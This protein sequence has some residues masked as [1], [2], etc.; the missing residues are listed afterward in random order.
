MNSRDRV[1]SR[2][3][4]IIVLAL[5]TC[6][7]MVLPVLA[8][9]TGD[10]SGGGKN[11]PL[12][13]VASSPADGQKD[14]PLT[15]TIKLSFNKNVI[16]LLIRDANKSCISLIA[17]DG[18]KVP[19][20]VIMADDQTPEGFEQRR[21]IS[22]RP[23]QGLQPGTAYAV[24]ISPQLQAKNGTSLGHE[25]TVRF[26]TA[27]VASKPVANMPASNTEK[28]PTTTSP[29]AST[30]IEKNAAVSSET[31]SP[32]A[33]KAQ[34]LEEAQ[35]AEDK[36]QPVEEKTPES[37]PV[38]NKITYAIVAGLILLAALGYVYFRKRNKK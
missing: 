17:P 34:T 18:S 8:E 1:K 16:Y 11:V 10:G 4:S 30:T 36:A 7:L 5:L 13:L 14:V 31:N 6:I 25:D 37:G 28:E 26:V 20:E 15:G 32:T 35:T 2:L 33:E 29:S 12:D 9:G 23:L 24:E 19:I 27:G 3:L 21:D 38:Q 22:V